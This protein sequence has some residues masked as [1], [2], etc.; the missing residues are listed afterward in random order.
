VCVISKV[1]MSWVDVDVGYRDEGIASFVET[2]L[3]TLTTTYSS[4]G[5]FNI[6]CKLSLIS[7]YHH[8]KNSVPK[9]NH[10]TFF[11]YI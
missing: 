1:Y 11:I 8:K 3:N 7:F 2:T 9:F 6:S 4:G 5:L 10:F